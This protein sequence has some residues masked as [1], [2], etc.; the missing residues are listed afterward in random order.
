MALFVR[1]PADPQLTAL[2]RDVPD[3]EKHQQKY[4]E[5][6]EQVELTGSIE[7]I[8][9]SKMFYNSGSDRNP[10]IQKRLVKAMRNDLQRNRKF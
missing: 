6:Q 10:E 4:V 9:I 1:I 5:A 8:E 7:V 2:D 3:Y